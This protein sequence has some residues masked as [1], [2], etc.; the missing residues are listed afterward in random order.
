MNPIHLSIQDIATIKISLGI[1][2]LEFSADPRFAEAYKRISME[3]SR[4]VSEADTPDIQE[5]ANC[6]PLIRGARG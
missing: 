1:C 6:G 4:A 2:K 3:F 5:V